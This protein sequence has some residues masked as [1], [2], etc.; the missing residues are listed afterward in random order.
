MER[1]RNEGHGPGIA[2]VASGATQAGAAGERP[3]REGLADERHREA[4][5]STHPRRGTD[6]S[7]DAANS[8]EITAELDTLIERL[9]PGVGLFTQTQ[10]RDAEGRYISGKFTPDIRQDIITVA[11]EGNPVETLRHEVL[12]ALRNAGLF[13]I[14]EWR[15]LQQEAVRKGWLGKYKIRERYPELYI[16]DTPTGFAIEEAI[17]DAFATWGTDARGFSS[18]TARL[19]ARLREFFQRLRHALRLGEFPVSVNSIFENVEIG[20]VGSRS[21]SLTIGMQPMYRR[22]EIANDDNPPALENSESEA[23]LVEAEKGIQENVLTA[24]LAEAWEVMRHNFSRHFPL[25]DKIPENAD[26]IQKLLHLEA[27]ASAGQDRIA[28]IF[29]RVVG[30]LNDGQ[31]RTLTRYLVF[32]DLLWTSEQGMQ[33]GFGLEGI[34]QIAIELRKL[35]ARV[36]ASP[37]IK[38]RY[39]VRQ[40]ELD[41][42]R[43][44]MVGA[45]VLTKAQARNPHYF[46]HQVLAYAKIKQ[47]AGQGK[48]VSSSFWH[49]REGSEK[50]IN[51]N[52]MQAEAEWMF[53]AIN[54]INTMRFLNWL[55]GSKYDKKPVYVRMA[56]ALN[57]QN[58]TAALLGDPDKYREYKTFNRKIAVAMGRF[59]SILQ[60]APQTALDAVPEE[61]QPQLKRILDGEGGRIDEGSGIFGAIGWLANKSQNP[62]LQDAAHGV[63]GAIGNRKNFVRKDAIPNQFVN[64]QSTQQL[65]KAFGSDADAIWQPDAFD[66]KTKAVHIFTGKSIPEF[67]EE[68]ML[69]A[70]TDAWEQVMAGEDAGITPQQLETFLK[71]IK[72]QRMLGGPKH[73]MILDASFATTLNE[74]S[75]PRGCR[76]FRR[77]GA[78]GHRAL[79]AMDD[80]QPPPLPEVHPQQPGGR[81]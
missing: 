8:P 60:S 14:P 5:D 70:V 39:D 45:G 24:K 3:R 73:E 79:E 15:T 18:R 36:D 32:K 52:Y 11:L 22:I 64:P 57:R 63:L 21:G 48:K 54:D 67:M 37:E 72:D 7:R 34:D 40:S 77:N 1:L 81:P 42:L 51:A 46:R 43:G 44:E 27:Q 53:K 28:N 23:R 2:G 20:I 62:T 55:K 35:Q 49:T 17:A 16:G 75:R 69:D 30:G 41:R 71:S 38:A 12:H 19:F 78:A 4:D 29:K 74:F 80:L 26:L 6:A 47:A 66:G 10:V 76:G 33:V 65:V 68:R 13:S 50:D 25:V 31:L 56:K 58:L 59:K 9:A 61:L